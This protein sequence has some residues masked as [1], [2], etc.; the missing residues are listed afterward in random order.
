MDHCP[1]HDPAG[2]PISNMAH[3][4]A[5]T[6]VGAQTLFGVHMTQY[7]T[8]MHKYQLVLRFSVPAEVAAALREIR[9]RHP[10]D[11]FVLANDESDEFNIPSVAAG[12]KPTFTG[13]IFQGIPP[14]GPEDEKDPHFFPWQLTRVRPVFGKIP[15]TVEHVVYFRPF[16]HAEPLPEVAHYLMFGRG[17]EAHMT[18]LQTAPVALAADGGMLFGP[19]YDHVLSLAGTP[20]WI[21]PDMLEA[22]IV[23]TVPSIP[24]R[25]PDGRPHIPCAIPM[26]E[27]E[28]VVLDYRG[29]PRDPPLT[30]VAGPSF[31]CA[32][33]VCN[34]EGLDVCPEDQSMH[35][36]ETPDEYLVRPDVR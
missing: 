36:S 6:I 8:E 1:E 7:H 27:G 10:R 13:N 12:L 25:G 15:V 33:A 22:G 14:F 2:P 5:F 4:H 17:A 28:A 32:T 29:L 21:A 30:A 20:H 18:D 31:F 3:Q 9:A 23:V 26:A 11:I 35:A 24:L 34:S 19:G 16:S